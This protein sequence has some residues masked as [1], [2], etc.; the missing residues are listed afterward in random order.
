MEEIYD[1][2][3]A[4]VGSTIIT[5]ILGI[6]ISILDK[7]RLSEEEIIEHDPF[8]KMLVEHAKETEMQFNEILTDTYRTLL[9]TTAFNKQILKNQPLQEKYCL[10]CEV[11]HLP[12]L[13]SCP[14]CQYEL[15]KRCPICKEI[16]LFDRCKCGW[17]G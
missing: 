14:V 7:P 6:I 10:N 11:V 5:I 13:K 12:E 15:V 2:V 3:L 9:G 1:L 4:I 8:I 16:V 17:Q